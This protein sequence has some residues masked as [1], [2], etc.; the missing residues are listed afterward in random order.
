[1]V[2]GASWPAHLTES[3]CH[4]ETLQKTRWT[5]PE[6]NTSGSL[7]PLRAHTQGHVHIDTHIH[8]GRIVEIE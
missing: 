8:V 6:R 1:M 4:S 3:P 5:A 7:W 2:P